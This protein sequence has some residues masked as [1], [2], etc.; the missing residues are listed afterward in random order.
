MRRDARS[1][2]QQAQEALRLR[3][4]RA[5]RQGMKQV[6]AAR[7]F[8]VTRQAIGKWMKKFREG[9]E[10]ALR[11]G[12]K[13]RPPTGGRLKGWQAAAICNLIRD[14][15][16]EQLKLPFVLWT[17]EAVR[18]LIQRRFRIRCSVRTVQRYL[19][20]WDFTPQKPRRRAWERDDAAVQRWLREEYPAIRRSAK[21]Q[22]ARIYWGDEMGMRSDHQAGRSYGPRGHTPVVPGTGQRFGCNMIS[23]ITN[24]GA[25]TFMVFKQRFVAA[26]FIQFLRRLIQQANRRVVLI[27]DRHPVHRSRKVQRWLAEHADQI[28]VFYLPGYSPEL[29]PDE[30]LNNDVKANALG[31]RRPHNQDELMQNIRGYLRHRKNKP[32][33]VKKYFHAESVRYAA[34]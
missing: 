32:E 13:G 10:A 4:V 30:M 5:V 11:A 2:S 9:G 15:H 34:A 23:A 29:N 8:G 17:A 27:L 14:R 25:L 24:R 28:R 18:Q 16:P 1:L 3:A 33:V 7:V 20:R 12:T 6:D 31:S 22:K 21:R 26:V 19:K